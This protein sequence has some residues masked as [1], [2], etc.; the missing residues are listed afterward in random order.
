[1]GIF[2]YVKLMLWSGIYYNQKEKSETVYKIIIKNIKDS[3]CVVIK[4][5][6]WIL[7]KIEALYNIDIDDPKNK[8]FLDLEEVYDN[9]NYHSLKYT[10]KKY[11]EVFNR[12]LKDDYIIDKLLASGSIGQVYKITD[13]KTKEKYAMKIIHP[14]VNDNLSIFMFIFKIIYI[15]PF[16]RN[17]IGYYLP[18]DIK[19]FFDDFRIQTDLIN[20]ANNCLQ[21]YNNYKNN[22]VYIIPEIKKVS[23]DIIIMSYEEGTSLDKSEITHYQKEKF[24]SLLK[25]FVKN[26]Q[27]CTKFMHGDLHKGNWKVNIIDNDV[28]LII[29]DYGFCW[30]MPDYMTDI[31][32]SLFVDR[33]MITPI[34]SVENFAKSCHILIN[35][36]IELDTIKKIINETEKEMLKDKRYNKNNLYD[37][38]IF[39]MKI[40][41]KSSRIGGFLLDTFCLHSVILH[42]QTTNYLER[43]DIVRKNRADNYYEKCV[44]DI[45]NLCDTYNV[46]KTYGEILKYDYNGS[47]IK[48]DDLFESVISDN[49]FLNDENFKKMA[50]YKED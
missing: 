46:C 21:F 32:Q 3:G 27:Y 19:T 23:K 16:L 44:L 28:K 41:F 40:I 43:Y 4:F 37:D 36:K 33:S 38:P 47:G 34:K 29:Y 35:K 13:I 6:Q 30:N 10:E 25:I 18:V 5:V 42:T 50:V 45:V 12:E 8:W 22:S 20:E 1:M 9:C 7:P 2:N 39:L 26:N 48:K 31:D 11:K 17:F 15:L 24:I 49:K 14:N